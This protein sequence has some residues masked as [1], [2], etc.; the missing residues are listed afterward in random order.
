[1]RQDRYHTQIFA[2]DA[3]RFYQF[4]NGITENAEHR[5]KIQN[6]NGILAFQVITV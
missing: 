5:I 6:N 3:I 1:M 2:E 4:Q